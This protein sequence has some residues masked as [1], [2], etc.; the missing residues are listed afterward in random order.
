MDE[1]WELYDTSALKDRKVADEKAIAAICTRFE[2][3]TGLQLNHLIFLTKENNQIN[4]NLS[5][6]L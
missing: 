2:R 1:S 4:I 5:V 6:D 3:D